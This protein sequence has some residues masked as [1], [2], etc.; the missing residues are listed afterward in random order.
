[1]RGYIG[2]MGGPPTREN[3]GVL[4]LKLDKGRVLGG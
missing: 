4:T 1:M 2:L 3:P